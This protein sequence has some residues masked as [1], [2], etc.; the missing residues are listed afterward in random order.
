MIYSCIVTARARLL[1]GFTSAR[2]FTRA[3][4]GIPLNYNLALIRIGLF[5]H[6]DAPLIPFTYSEVTPAR[7]RIQQYSI[8]P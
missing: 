5:V 8:A 6:S 4:R 7:A 1:E 2:A 3:A